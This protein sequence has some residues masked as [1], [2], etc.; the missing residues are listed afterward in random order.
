[1]SLNNIHAEIIC[2]SSHD[3]LVIDFINVRIDLTIVYSVF[4]KSG[5]IK[6]AKN[7]QIRKKK[8]KYRD[9]VPERVKL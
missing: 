9:S 1:M 7:G 4:C 5:D 3:D 6:S 2:L 8:Q